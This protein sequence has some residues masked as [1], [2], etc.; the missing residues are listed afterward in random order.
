QRK[1]LE[2]AQKGIP[3][4]GNRPFGYQKDKL[5]LEPSE[6]ALLEEAAKDLL[7]GVGL[8]TICRRWND[9]GVK[10]TV[11]NPWRKQVLRNLLL[12]PRLAGYRVYQGGIARDIDGNPVM[13]Q[14]PP[15]LERG[16]WE[17]VCAVL[18]DPARCSKY[19]H[20]GG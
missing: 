5:T 15:I 11:G 7:A 20:V 3:V 6:A 4:G 9:A 17:A 10:T 2:L 1:H 8:H 19:V 16:T 12:S 14:Y 18:Q 13:G